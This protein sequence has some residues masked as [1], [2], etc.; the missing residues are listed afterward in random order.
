MANASAQENNTS[1]DNSK[2][3][4]TTVFLDT[5]NKT[6]H[7][8]YKEEY[9]S[10][11]GSDGV[12]LD[13]RIKYY[14]GDI[15]ISSI[16]LTFNRPLVRSG[17]PYEGSMIKAIVILENETILNN[18]YRD[19]PKNS[20]GNAAASKKNPGFEAMAALGLIS[21]IYLIRRRK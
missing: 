1:S 10:Q 14:E 3:Q 2:N 16:K 8:V 19:R 21:L 5:K 6:G 20:T 13:K 15:N 7:L 11:D 9:Y 18:W 4:Q 12:K 17:M